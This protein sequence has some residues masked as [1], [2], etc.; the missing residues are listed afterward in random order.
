[1]E[2][3]GNTHQH[4]LLAQEVTA[5]ARHGRCKQWNLCAHSG[6]TASNRAALL[7]CGCC[8]C[9]IWLP[10]VRARGREGRGAEAGARTLW[11]PMWKVLGAH[12][13]G[14]STG[15]WAGSPRNDRGTRQLTRHEPLGDKKCLAF[16]SANH[17]LHSNLDWKDA[18]LDLKGNES[19]KRNSSQSRRVW[20]H[21]VSIPHTDSWSLTLLCA[22]FSQLSTKQ[23]F[24]YLAF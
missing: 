8:R 21:C 4:R 16:P 3:T 5:A 18:V 1:M 2:G 22:S 20:S 10:K 17:M 15:L 23:V 19:D 12:S 14:M 7:C 11:A 24:H 13:W 6:G 9:L